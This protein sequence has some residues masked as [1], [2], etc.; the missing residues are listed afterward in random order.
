MTSPQSASKTAQYV[1]A[2]IYAHL[3][4]Y[5]QT[6]LTL[7]EE[8]QFTCAAER[9]HRAQPQ[10]SRQVHEVEVIMGVQIF[11]RLHG[12]V[13]L[14]RGGGVLV[15]AIKRGIPYLHRCVSR[16][17][18]SASSPSCISHR[19]LADLCLCSWDARV[20]PP[21]SRSTQYPLRN[22][23]PVR[24]AIEASL[25]LFGGAYRVFQTAA[26]FRRTDGLSQSSHGPPHHNRNR[27]RA[28]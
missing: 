23:Q 8:E 27:L 17:A 26:A 14:T 19:A 24:F 10:V 4:R 12:G 2:G 28:A 6:V 3:D 20:K 9:L 7:A 16:P 1:E 15:R 5:F 22:C 25:A 13:R 11:E 18:L 21:E